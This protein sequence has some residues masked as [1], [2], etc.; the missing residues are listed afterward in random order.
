MKRLSDIDGSAALA[1]CES[2]LLALTD[3]KILDEREVVGLMEDAAGAH[4]NAM[5]ESG[6]DRGH[7]AVAE[8]IEA[9]IDGGNSVRRSR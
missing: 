6:G 3:R 8:L 5:T 4:R 7:R 1:I 2:L 9:I